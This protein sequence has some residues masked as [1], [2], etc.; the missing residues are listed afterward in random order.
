MKIMIF[1][2]CYLKM[3]SWSP[4]NGLKGFLEVFCFNLTEHEAVRSHG[5]PIHVIFDQKDMKCL[6]AQQEDISCLLDQIWH[7]KVHYGSSRAHVQSD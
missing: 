1:L 5:E 6:L 3:T 4:G 2:K 7:E